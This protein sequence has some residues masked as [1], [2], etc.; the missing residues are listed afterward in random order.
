MGGG[1]N[2]EKTDTLKFEV[3]KVRDTCPDLIQDVASI[4]L[5]D[6]AS[7]KQK[8]QCHEKQIQTCCSVFEVYC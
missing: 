4:Y 5:K 8:H 7:L 2:G 3:V 6:E 1:E